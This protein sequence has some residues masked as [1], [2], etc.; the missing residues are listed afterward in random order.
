MPHLL[1]FLHLILPPLLKVAQA[2]LDGGAV[3]SLKRND[4]RTALDTTRGD[5]RAAAVASVIIGRIF[6]Q[7]IEPMRSDPSSRYSRLLV[8]DVQQ[9]VE[10]YVMGK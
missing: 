6:T 3:W 4:G 1:T 8:R 10:R 9:L 7:V 5:A 2:L